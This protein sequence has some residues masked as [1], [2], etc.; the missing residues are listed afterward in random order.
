[1][2]A[3]DH[4]PHSKE[5]KS[6][7]LLGSAF[8]IVGIETAFPLMY[9]ELVRKNVITMDRLM[10]LLVWNARRRFDIPLENSFSVWDLK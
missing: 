7:G 5:E 8:G 10:D 3:T 6:R 1:M 4:A 2:I 9:T